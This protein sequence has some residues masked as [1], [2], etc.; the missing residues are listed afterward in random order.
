MRC[1]W[2][3]EALAAWST[4]A[5]G[6]CRRADPRRVEVFGAAP[7]RLRMSLM[8]TGE[9]EPSRA[10]FMPAPCSSSGQSLRNA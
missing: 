4:L 9:E 1:S 8:Q 2:S 10:P 6:G 5:A 3:R 7:A